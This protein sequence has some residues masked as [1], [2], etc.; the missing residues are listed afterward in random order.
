MATYRL[1]LL[2][3]AGHVRESVV[4]DCQSDADALQQAENHR[5]PAMELWNLDRMVQSFET[6]F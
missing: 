5:G 1:Y 6:E 4:M 2:D 3:A